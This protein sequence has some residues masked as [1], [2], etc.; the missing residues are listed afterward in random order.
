M[1]KEEYNIP[2]EKL[3]GQ[4]FDKERSKVLLVLR[5]RL[6][7]T[8]EDAE[9]IYQNACIALY[10]NIQKGKLKTLT[11]SLYT[12]FSQICL[13]M[14]YNFV[15][16]GHSTTSFDQLVDNTQY[17]EYDLAK[18]EAVL[19][20]GQGDRLSSKQVAMMRDIVQDLPQPCEQILWL[21]Y[22]DDLSMKEIADIIGFNGADSV[23]SK[24]SQCM[25][26]LK[27]RFNKI[28]KSFY[29]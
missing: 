2:D 3:L 16:R 4:F 6:S 11:C 5:N 1:T 15:N 18:L 25:S 12:Y 29:E 17:D 24:K 26:K 7:I 28:I 27:E 21:Y 20:L 13:N 9:D 23:K 14:G 19:G 8:T 22:G 10:N